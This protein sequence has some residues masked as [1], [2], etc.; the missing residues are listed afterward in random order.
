[1]SRAAVVGGPRGQ[2]AGHRSEARQRSG[3]ARCL[4][5]RTIGGQ[6][7]QRATREEA[8]LRPGL[9]F[10]CQDD[11][12]FAQ[13][14]PHSGSSETTLFALVRPFFESACTCGSYHAAHW[15]CTSAR[16]CGRLDTNGQWRAGHWLGWLQLSSRRE[17]LL[18][19]LSRPVTFSGAATAPVEASIDSN[20]E[21]AE[22]TQAVI[23][24]NFRADSEHLYEVYPGD[25]TAYATLWPLSQAMMGMLSVSKLA[26]HDPAPDV[27]AEFDPYWDGGGGLVKRCG[28]SFLKAVDQATASPPRSSISAHPSRAAG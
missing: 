18:L 23:E 6:R 4:I 22:A 13:P 8:S 11:G 25:P 17:L 26:G 14:Y 10:G 5:L 2:P 15:S 3:R 20:L 28:L 12:P 27:L 16:G 21:R 7:N 24:H 19:L 1:M 9:H